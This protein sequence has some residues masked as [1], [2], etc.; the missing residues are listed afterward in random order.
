MESHLWNKDGTPKR[1]D[2]AEY[3]DPE[4]YAQAPFADLA[5]KEGYLNFARIKREARA[6][7]APEVGDIVH[8]W[9]HDT[10]YAAMV[11]ETESF[12]DGACVRVHVPHKAFEDYQ[13]AHDED[14]EFI[15]TWHWPCGEG[16]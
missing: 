7:R 16:Q 13:S 9:N 15:E 6:Q 1:P 4:K 11:M 5:S 10:C 12:G 8:F 14:K 2:S 3:G